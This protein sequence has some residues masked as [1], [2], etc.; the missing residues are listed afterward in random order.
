[1]K[2][3][4]VESEIQEAIRAHIERQITVKPG[5]AI[6]MEIRATRG[7]DGFI[8]NIDISPAKDGAIHLGPEPTAE[9]VLVPAPT[10]APVE[11]QTEAPAAIRPRV[12]RAKLTEVQPPVIEP[13]KDETP[14]DGGEPM[15][16]NS[17][18]AAGDG[19][20]ADEGDALEPTKSVFSSKVNE[21]ADAAAAADDGVQEVEGSAPLK[22]SIFAGLARPTND[23]DA[24]AA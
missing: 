4:I 19:V 24:A 14:F 11:V 17:T 10:P 9:K 1:M 16:D 2:I 7:D 15:V 23:A 20:Q 13:A 21:A 5:M 12:T 22:R 6:T 3:T 8:A 18:E